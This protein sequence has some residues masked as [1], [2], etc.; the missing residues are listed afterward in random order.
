MRTMVIVLSILGIQE[1][2]LPSW[3]RLFSP[4][5]RGDR[6]GADNPNLIALASLFLPL[7]SPAK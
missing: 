1:G 5:E 6:S 2:L 7:S 3:R 4:K